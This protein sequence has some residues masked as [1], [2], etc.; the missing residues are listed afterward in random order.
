LLF[1]FKG[2]YLEEKINYEQI[3]IVGRAT[4]KMLRRKIKTQFVKQEHNTQNAI[5]FELF[6]AHCAAKI[7][8]RTKVFTKILYSNF[9]YRLILHF[10]G[11][12]P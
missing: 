7:L 8:L 3:T 6:K 11:F 2:L 10:T 4:L 12:E 1:L 9:L 5:A